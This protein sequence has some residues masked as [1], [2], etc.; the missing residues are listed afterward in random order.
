MELEASFY[1]YRENFYSHWQKNIL[2]LSWIVGFIILGIEIFTYF[3]LLSMDE[4]E[5]RRF[6]YICARIV[7]PSVINFG[8][9]TTI[10][11]VQKSR[12]YKSEIKNLLVSLCFFIICAILSIFH[13]YFQILL[14]STCISLF[15]CTIFG[16]VKILKIL[17]HATIPVFIIAAITFWTDPLTGV[18]MYKIL[19]IICAVAFIACSYIFAKA[20]VISQKDH[21]KYIS[22]IYKKQS[23]LI[24][25]LR[26]DPLT[27]LCN[28]IAF[29]ETINRIIRNSRNSE[30]APFIVIMDI[31]Y[32]KKV[33]DKYGH[34]AGDEVLVKLADILRNNVSS[35][36]TFR[37][38]GE[39]F[40]LLFE[41][42]IESRVVNVVEKIREEFANT[43]FDFALEESFKISAGISAFSKSFDDKDWLE[44]ADKALYY[45]KENGRDQIK[46]AEIK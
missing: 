26:I 30:A 13:N 8:T 24:A 20:I 45:A 19:T 25:E 14:L 6:S 44:N 3:S 32:F 5:I 16:E 37:F 7:I 40:I 1:H 9:L 34:I 15:L 46:V 38:G 28:R 21:L 18:R 11:I 31:D 17:F 43:H 36:K 33:N 41:D 23:E 12:R 10:T 27:K 39:E 42:D 4:R 22:S 2:R 35:R 29:T